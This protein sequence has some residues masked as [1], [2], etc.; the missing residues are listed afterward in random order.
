MRAST[1]FKAGGITFAIVAILALG[2]LA[3]ATFLFK[4]PTP[5]RSYREEAAR[6]LNNDLWADPPEQPTI[7][8]SKRL[9]L[10]CAS[11]HHGI[12][13][14]PQAHVEFLDRWQADIDRS[15]PDRAVTTALACR[16]DPENT[17]P[18]PPVVMP[19]V[20]TREP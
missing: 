1:I 10:I 11:I 8:E 7:E 5:D 19:M 15:G 13:D 18:S 17:D 16:Q 12:P 20:A 2:F 14:S 4:E 9:L 3:T 6:L